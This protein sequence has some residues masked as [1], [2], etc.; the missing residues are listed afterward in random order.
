[1]SAHPYEPL[2]AVPP[3][4]QQQRMSWLLQMRRAARR[5][6]DAALA[7][8][9]RAA[10]YVSRL[11]QSTSLG[12][13]AAWVQRRLLHVT[14]PLSHLVQRLGRSGLAAAALSILSSPSGQAAV[15]RA[16]RLTGRALSWLGRTSYDLLDRGLRCLG[17]PGHRAADLLFA[18]TVRFGGRVAAVAAPAVHRVARLTDPT[19]QSMRLLAAAGRSFLLHRLVKGLVSNPLVRLVSQAI[20]IPA[21]LDSR[22]LTWLRALLR[23]TRIR[24]EALQ[25]QQDTLEQMQLLDEDGLPTAATDL[26]LPSNRAERRAAERQN[27]HQQH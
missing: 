4:P 15:R 2:R 27:R 1:M 8:P 7:A 10:E 3:L 19:S 22:L 24:V 6:L 5:A 12:R 14:G 17:K 9:R 18:S 11:L 25:R 20:L 23:Q 13:A 26:P 21:I 16:L